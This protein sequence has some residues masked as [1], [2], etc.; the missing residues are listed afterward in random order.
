MPE[1]AA[2]AGAAAADDDDSSGDEYYEPEPATQPLAAAAAVLAAGL[3]RLSLDAVAALAALLPA[4]AVCALGG[5]C[6]ALRWVRE[7]VITPTEAMI[8]LKKTFG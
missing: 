8:H 3:D 5:S 7:L 1:A 2:A 6:R 4:A